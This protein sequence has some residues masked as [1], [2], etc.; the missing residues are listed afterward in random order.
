MSKA[1][2]HQSSSPPALLPLPIRQRLLIGHVSGLVYTHELRVI[3]QLCTFDHAVDFGLNNHHLLRL[4]FG[5][6]AGLDQAFGGAGNGVTF[7]LTRQLGIV[8]LHL[9]QLMVMSLAQQHVAVG[10]EVAGTM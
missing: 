3:F 6:L 9:E 10:R 2:P 1:L 8:A 5:D 4:F 7:R